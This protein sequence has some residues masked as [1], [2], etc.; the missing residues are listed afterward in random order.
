ME[1]LE[2]KRLYIQIYAASSTVIAN[3]E[4]KKYAVFISNLFSFTL[5]PVE[6]KRTQRLNIDFSQDSNALF[7]FPNEKGESIYTIQETFSF[8]EF[9]NASPAL[10]K[11]MIVEN[12][13][14]CLYKLY[15]HLELNPSDVKLAYD[16]ILGNNF[17]LSVQLCGGIK[18][19]RKRIKAS[20]IAEHFLD[21]TLIRVVFLDAEN[22]V[23]NTVN[24]FKTLPAY[25]IYTQ[26]VNSAKWANNDV[27]YLF[28]NTKEFEIRI[29]INGNHNVCYYPKRRDVNGIKE[30]IKFL[31]PQILIDIN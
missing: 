30:E 23:L 21:Y 6:I 16:Q 31:S 5:P 22:V 29:G 4:F 19:N 7:I 15:L 27:F 9:K 28:N 26:L 24:L 1:Q 18:T 25:F 8:L 3:D 10:K 2:K 12:A 13:C 14:Q 17:E 20:V 11:R